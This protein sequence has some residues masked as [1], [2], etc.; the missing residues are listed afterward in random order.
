MFPLGVQTSNS[1]IWL[2]AERASVLQK[3][4]RNT[5]TYAN[6]VVQFAG[7][8][9]YQSGQDQ[10]GAS[11]KVDKTS[12]PLIGLYDADHRARAL[13]SGQVDQREYIAFVLYC[14]FFSSN[15]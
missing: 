2:F 3:R 12:Y 6:S 1:R 15:K 8:E 5:R 11:E 14:I 7:A 4:T 10:N 13:A 9:V